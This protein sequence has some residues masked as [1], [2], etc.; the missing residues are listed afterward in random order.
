MTL[1][2]ARA[3]RRTVIA[4]LEAR[5]HNDY[6]RA[7]CKRD[8]GTRG[9]GAGIRCSTRCAKNPAVGGRQSGALVIASAKLTGRW[10]DFGLCVA[11][12]ISVRQDFQLGFRLVQI[13]NKTSILLTLLLL[14]PATNPQVPT[15][16]SF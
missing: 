14:G 5:F 6:A 11:Q 16:K 4:E 7:D 3:R 8:E 15:S 9:R 10:P 1:L 12:R 2:A 13:V